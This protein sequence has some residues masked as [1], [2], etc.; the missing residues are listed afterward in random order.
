MLPGPGDGTRRLHCRGQGQLASGCLRG[1]PQAGPHLRADAQAQQPLPG[2][3]HRAAG[4]QPT[5]PTH[6]SA[7]WRPM[8]AALW[9]PRCLPA[10][11]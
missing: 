3:L 4:W 2:S 11:S 7:L 9:C 10:A 1:Q 6:Y 8:I 5:V